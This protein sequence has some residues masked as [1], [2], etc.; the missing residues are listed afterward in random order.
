VAGSFTDLGGG[1]QSGIARFRIDQAPGIA[2]LAAPPPRGQADG[3][4]RGVSPNPFAHDSRIAFTLPR[5]GRVDVRVRDLQG[6]EV[7]APARDAWRP[8]GPGILE[9][10]AGDLPGGVYLLSLEFEGRRET[11][12]VVRLR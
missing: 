10:N 4:L 6:R 12:R 3:V 8:A 1:A 5:A 11:R 2:A 7:A 9:W